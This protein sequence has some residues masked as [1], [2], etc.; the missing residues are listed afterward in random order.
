MNIAA[1]KYRRI[2]EAAGGPIA[3]LSVRNISKSPHVTRFEAYAYLIGSLRPTWSQKPCIYGNPDGTGTAPYR[4]QACYRA[5]SE[6]VERWAFYSTVDSEQ[7]RLYGFDLEPSTAGMAAFPE[8]NFSA[9]S[10][11]A[12][13]IALQ[14]AIERWS[15]CAWWE[16]L[17][18]VR[19]IDYFELGGDEL[20]SG[21]S[22]FGAVEILHPWHRE[23]YSVILIWSRQKRTGVATYGFACEKNI[24]RA[25]Y[26][27]RMEQLRSIAGLEQLSATPAK[28]DWPKDVLERRLL[29]FSTFEGYS[30]FLGNFKRSARTVQLSAPLLL[31]DSELSGPWSHYSTV[32]RCLFKMPSN[33]HLSES[34][35]YFQF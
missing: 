21:E 31:V 24:R 19:R 9:F 12:R 27:A 11:T 15:V 22:D 33:E 35:A 6:A 13:R 10:P 20:L 28:A 29:Y 30:Q 25:Y 32:W 8:I 1:W 2:T 14:E 18:N 7:S 5:I 3:R 34:I 17:L 16:G 23:G 4:N 26:R